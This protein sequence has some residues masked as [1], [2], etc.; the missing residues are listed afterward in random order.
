MAK[1]QSA[2]PELIKHYHDSY[3]AATGEKPHING[4]KDGKTLQTL[5]KAYGKETVR[6]TITAMVQSQD[7]FILA[8][9]RT[10]GVLSSCWNKLRAEMKRQHP[11][12]VRPEACRHQP[13]C[14]DAAACTKRRLAEAK[15][16]A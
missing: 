14:T 9:G 1:E 7:P 5:T 11:V 4:P 8:S 10:M 3:L 6:D 2:V 13:A 12:A 15:G 16:A